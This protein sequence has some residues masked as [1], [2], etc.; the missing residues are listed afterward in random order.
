MSAVKN[1]IGSYTTKAGVRRYKV[2]MKVNGKTTTYGKFATKSEAERFRDLRRAEVVTGDWIDPKKGRTLFGEYASSWVESEDLERTTKAMYRRMLDGR[3]AC[4]HDVPLGQINSAD[5]RAWVGE[6]RNTPSKKT[7]KPLARATVVKT[8]TLLHKV[9]SVAVDDGLIRSNPCHVN[10]KKENPKRFYCPSPDDV[11][12]LADEVPH[13]YRALILIAGFGGLRWGECIGLTRRWVDLDASTV[14]VRQ[15]V[16][17]TADGE[18]YLQ[19]RGKTDAAVRDVYVPAVVRQALAL[20][21]ATYADPGPD[22]LL[23]PAT[24]RS[25]TKT[26]YV[27]REN[28]RRQVWLKAQKSLDLPPIRFHDLR[29]AAATLLAQSGA[30]TRELMEQIGHVNPD[31]AIRYQHATEDRRKAIPAKLD[32]LIPTDSV[33]S[34][35]T[36]NVIPLR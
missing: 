12:A 20:H 21:L 28:F 36:D 9:M 1:G 29:H 32:A 8:Y 31:A 4:W 26:P 24:Q 19:E 34:T 5:V 23:F 16:A 2:V 27:R 7:G 18:M 25:R 22:G 17:E 15:T 11:L 35:G 6:M 14:S 10:F 3:L 13:R 33:Q 30:T